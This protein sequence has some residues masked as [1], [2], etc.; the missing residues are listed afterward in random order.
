MAEE[1]KVGA[2]RKRT[3]GFVDLS[4]NVN[5]S[6]NITQQDLDGKILP[7]N[8]ILDSFAVTVKERFEPCIERNDVFLRSI[9]RT[10]NAVRIDEE[11]WRDPTVILHQIFIFKL[12]NNNKNKNKN[13]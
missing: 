11:I 6:I 5:S 9:L 7:Q 13:S 12:T 8:G 4:P 3:L 10:E 1:S 2:I